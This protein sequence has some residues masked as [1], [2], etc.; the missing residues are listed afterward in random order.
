MITPF[1]PEKT[2]INGKSAGLS[3]CSYDIRTARKIELGPHPGEIVSKALL[4]ATNLFDGPAVLTDLVAALRAAPPCRT[5][6]VSLERFVIPKNVSGY[7]CDKSTYARLHVT[8]FN[9][10]F[11]PGFEGFATLE[12]V[13]LGSKPVTIEAG[14][15]ICQLV[16]HWLDQETDRPYKGKFQGQE[17]TPVGPR[18]EQLD[19]SYVE[20]AA[21]AL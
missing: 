7:V 12:I 1:L 17:Q 19:G 10:L 18:L 9:T 2:V 20:G 16:F 15:P 5:L 13:N 14:D 4:A 3:A 6:G 21:T 8:A 11:D